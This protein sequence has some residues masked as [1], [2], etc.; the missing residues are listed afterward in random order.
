MRIE[1][2]SAAIALGLV[3]CA[4]G[5]QERAVAEEWS[6]SVRVELEIRERALFPERFA[7]EAG[8]PAD[9]QARHLRLEAL[10]RRP[11]SELGEREQAFVLAC[12]DDDHPNLRSTALEVCARHGACRGALADDE[13]LQRLAAD[14]LPAVRRGLAAALGDLSGGVASR[15][16][17]SLE[18]DVDPDVAQEA[19]YRLLARGPESID[20]Q[21]VLFRLDPPRLDGREL[22]ET[23]EVLDLLPPSTELLDR[24]SREW[25]EAAAGESAGEAIDSRRCLWEALRHSKGLVAD[26]V[27]LGRGWAARLDAA[28]EDLERDRRARLLEDVRRG[29]GSLHIPLM[30]ALAPR[31]VDSRDVVEQGAPLTQEERL[32]FL[33]GAAESFFAHDSATLVR[34]AFPI[35]PDLDPELLVRF[36]EVAAPVA[37]KWVSNGLQVYYTLGPELRA[38]AF[39]AFAQTW[40]RTGDSGARFLVVLGLDY[41]DLAVDAY[42]TLVPAPFP[43]AE[44]PRVWRWWNERPEEEKLD[45]LRHHRPGLNYTSWRDSLLSYWSRKSGR[46]VVVAELLAGY[47]GDDEVEELLKLWIENE[48]RILE[49]GP[50]PDEATKEG[51]WREAET[52][53]GWLLKSWL[54]VRTNRDDFDEPG[55]EVELLIRVGMLG[56]ELGKTLVNRLAAYPPGRKALTEALIRPELSRRLRL[57]ILL[58][59]GD[60]QEPDQLRE[61]FVAYPTCDSELKAR[62][63][64]RA[65]GLDDPQVRALLAEVAGDP[66]AQ[67]TERM[68]AIEALATGPGEEVV[69]LLAEL[70]DRGGDADLERIVIEALGESASSL[71]GLDLLERMRD[72]RTRE[73]Q[74]DVLLPALVRIELRGAGELSADVLELW[75]SEA[76]GRAA[77]ELEQRLRGEAVP[78]REF[79]YSGWFEAAH[80]LLDAGRLEESLGDA[81]WKWDGRLLARLGLLVLQNMEVEHIDVQRRIDQAALTAISGEAEAADRMSEITILRGRLMQT[82]RRKPDWPAARA[83][84]SLLAGDWRRGRIGTN[85]MQ[86]IFGTFDRAEEQDTRQWLL[87][88]EASTDAWLDLEAGRLEEA[89][90]GA[91]RAKSLTGDSS[92]AKAEVR[93]LERALRDAG[94]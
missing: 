13:R 28:D 50:V 60:L 4:M 44:G 46:D 3:G 32:W 23:L 17:L 82:S 56:K 62:I 34:R 59:N 25:R 9:W 11:P 45:L 30:K 92:V 41:P 71:A 5:S 53:A 68:A 8:V 1:V 26:P 88:I 12:V 77:Q 69:P 89:A 22:L 76:D 75:R 66:G 94:N 90:E 6:R 81:Y 2:C 49:A 54:V 15:W 39:D 86:S 36:F 29:E 42:R 48:V 7:D 67:V 85:S 24:V 93:R 78:D 74:G 72:P 43:V 73:N 80:A 52:R 38:A 70:L 16:L 35:S 14:P 79:V 55:P 31:L 33:E 47:K 91:R 10:L 58:A 87:T 83:W 40:S 84:V 18:E 65:A 64:R 63:L 27:A 37:V 19:R 20:A 21:L 51:A 61:L 57:E